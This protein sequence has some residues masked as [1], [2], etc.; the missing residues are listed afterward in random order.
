MTEA[1]PPIERRSVVTQVRDRLRGDITSGRLTTGTLYSVNVIA[2]ELG[3][4]RTPVR[5]ALLQLS[6]LGLIEVHRNRGF[7]V[8]S[9]SQA[10]LF[11]IFQLRLAIET[12]AARRAAHRGETGT[13][14]EHMTAMETAAQAE[15]RRAFMEAD[16]AFHDALL[17]LATNKRARDAVSV[18]RDAIF[19]RGVSAS[20]KERTW[21][22]LVAEHQ[23]L[24]EAVTQADPA[25]AAVAMS[26]HLVNTADALATQTTGP[27]FDPDWAA[28]W[29]ASHGS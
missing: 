3:V 11:E 16:R 28:G 22:D 5:E 4:S 9:V 15:D 17:E 25:R 13:M 6:E 14:A 18:A 26:R 23:E 20:G 12:A 7:T 29:S 19:S 1:P 2:T 24:L 27:G 10:E 8:A 21:S